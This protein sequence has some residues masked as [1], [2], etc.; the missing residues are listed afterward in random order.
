METQSCDLSP[1]GAAVTKE[2]FEGQGKLHPKGPQSPSHTSGK[3]SWLVQ[4]V[5]TLPLQQ[6]F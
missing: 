6:L 5:D 3:Y 4:G 2:G 1:D